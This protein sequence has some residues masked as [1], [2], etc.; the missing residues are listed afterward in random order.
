[1]DLALAGRNALVT[2]GERGIGKDIC[3]ALAREGVNIAY[4]GET[5]HG[6]GQAS[7]SAG[8]TDFVQIGIGHAFEEKIV[9]LQAIDAQLAGL[10]DPIEE[11]HRFVN[12]EVVEEALGKYSQLRHP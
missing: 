7:G 4:C 5:Q 12:D 1:M 3:L 2:G 6:D 9:H 10:S 8:R 11:R